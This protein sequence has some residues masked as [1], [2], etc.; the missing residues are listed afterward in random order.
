MPADWSDG[1]LGDVAQI[2]MGQS[3]PSEFVSEDEGSGL[4]FLQGNAEFT[5]LHPRARL[6]CR[7]PLKTA[8]FGDA[9][10][11]VRAPVGAINL[12]DR[13]YCI[14][15]GLAAVR[16]HKADHQFGY[17]AIAVRSQ[18]LRRVAQGTTF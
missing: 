11:S 1:L 14:G 18:A 7:K 2:H 15:R 8:E 3:P 16:F 12:A 5:D 4:A 13:A 9:L 17:H 10:I 6:W